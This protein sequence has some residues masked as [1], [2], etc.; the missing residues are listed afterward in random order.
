MFCVVTIE[1]S[2][3]R[4]IWRIKRSARELQGDDK[5]IQSLERNESSCKMVKIHNCVVISIVIAVTLINQHGVRLR[6]VLE[7]RRMKISCR[8]LVGCF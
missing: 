2:E 5:E 7:K 8:W 3:W 4:Y 1:K 6:D